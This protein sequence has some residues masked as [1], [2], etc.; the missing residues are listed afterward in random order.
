M[1]IINEK[2]RLFGIINP[3]D[4]VILLVVLLAA[5]G[6]GVKVFGA[7]EAAVEKDMV[8]ATVT[9][10]CRG[11]MPEIVAGI[12]NSNP[13]GQTL[14]SNNA[15]TQGTIKSVAYSDYMNIATTDKGE[16]LY[17][18]DPIRKNLTFTIEAPVDRASNA[19]S[20][21]AQEI[22][23]GASFSIKTKY[24]HINGTIESIVFTEIEEK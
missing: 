2:G 3:V 12:Q 7:A 14:L 19:P 22:R 15:T 6:I 13:V 5:A 17:K 4:L 9:V 10:Q 20:I 11:A 24:I 21:G 8:M 1:K 16:F 23:V 18:V